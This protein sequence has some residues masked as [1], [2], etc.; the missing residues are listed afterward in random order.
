VDKVSDQFRELL[1]TIA[2]ETRIFNNWLTNASAYT[3][4][5]NMIKL[6]FKYN[7]I[8]QLFVSMMITQ[9]KET[10]RNDDLGVFWKTV[11]YLIS[12]NILF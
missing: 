7:E 12:S 11:Q 6:P 5:A 1:G 10:A 4:V 2:I 8:I 9:N 3:T